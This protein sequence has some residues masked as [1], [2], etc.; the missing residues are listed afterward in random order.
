MRFSIKG[1]DLMVTV[2]SE[3]KLTIQETMAAYQLA[4]GDFEA[5]FI[6]DDEESTS[7]PQENNV[8]PFREFEV[9]NG[10]II[11]KGT[12]VYTEVNCCFCGYTGKHKS[13]WLDFYI[14]CPQ[15]KKALFNSYATGVEFEENSWGC[16]YLANTPMKNKNK[17]DDLEKHFLEV[18]GS[19][20]D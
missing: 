9:H 20:Y 3:R 18:E 5:L 8:V 16:V 4:T 12:Q 10:K 6:K 14:K 7:V 1:K 19:T 11:E 2:K 13:R 17:D 15:C